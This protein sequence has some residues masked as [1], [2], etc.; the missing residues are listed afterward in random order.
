MKNKI[1][2]ASIYAVTFLVVTVII[3]MLN[4]NY[5]N[6]FKFD[7]STP[8]GKDIIHSGVPLQ[9]LAK[10]KKGIENVVREEYKD[11]IDVMKIKT[12]AEIAAVQVDPILLDSI[13]VLKAHLARLEKQKAEQMRKQELEAVQDTGK[14]AYDKWLKNAISYYEAM[15]EDQAAKIITK[16][17]DNVARDIIYNMKKKKAV[18]ILSALKPE[19]VNR[20]IQVEQ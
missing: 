8:V 13:K 4:N 2:A 14:V 16:Y 15:D 20:L 11:S 10:I 12:E 17:S 5:R 3:A 7:F 1:I 18:K 19:I 9:N 6:I